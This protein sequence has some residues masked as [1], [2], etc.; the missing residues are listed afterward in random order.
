MRRESLWTVMTVVALGMLA[1]LHVVRRDSA[2]A[3]LQEGAPVQYMHKTQQLKPTTL[4]APTKHTAMGEPQPH[5]LKR[6]GDMG[7]EVIDMPIANA[8]HDD[9]DMHVPA[10]VVAENNM[11]FD[12]QPKPLKSILRSLEKAKVN[13]KLLSLDKAHRRLKKQTLKAVYAGAPALSDPS[14]EAMYATKLETLGV[15]IGS[16]PSQG[17]LSTHGDVFIK[18]DGLEGSYSVSP[19][20]QREMMHN[21]IGGDFFGH[22]G[23]A[24]WTKEQIQAQAR[25]APAHALPTQALASLPHGSTSNGWCQCAGAGS[26]EHAKCE[27]FAAAA[28]ASKTVSLHMSCC[29]C[30]GD[31]PPG[32][33]GHPSWAAPAK[34]CSLCTTD[35]SKMAYNPLYNPYGIRDLDSRQVPS[36]HYICVLILLYVCPRNIVYDYVSPCSYISSVL[37][38]LCFQRQRPCTHSHIKPT[39]LACAYS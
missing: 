20:P 16:H 39:Y 12:K 29:K 25:R 21:T 27:C 28:K 5:E 30:G 13:P 33:A 23:D 14:D 4:G 7:D 24:L 36:H 38:L 31:F 35:C 2:S 10:E 3:L 9:G 34:A 1:G 26:G 6:G 22:I 32:A 11:M 15:N 37:I 18:T 17:G 8:L 19:A